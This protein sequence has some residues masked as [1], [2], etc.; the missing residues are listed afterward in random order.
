MPNIFTRILLPVDFSV[1][2]EIAVRRAVQLIGNTESAIHLIHIFSPFQLVTKRPGEFHLFFSVH[3]SSLYKENLK[4]LE[5]W[6]KTLE[7][8]LEKTKVTSEIIISDNVE[9]SIIRKSANFHPFLIILGRH[10]FKSPTSF[11]FTISS[12]RIAHLTRCAVLTLM[13]GI[14]PVKTQT[15]VIPVSDFV[16]ARKISILGSLNSNMK[17][18]V[19]LVSLKDVTSGPD[20][21]TAN[22]MIQTF[23]LLKTSFSC[24]VECKIIN[25][26]NLARGA[27]LFAQSVHAD[28]M[29]VHPYS[30]TDLPSFTDTRLVR[31]A[32]PASGLQVLTIAP[33]DSFYYQN[34]EN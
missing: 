21:G 2:T 16:P 15:V 30:E 18:K 13:P 11:R 19:F 26:T 3:K 6:K 32:G 10:S 12:S 34:I 22:A 31:T 9:K 28:M 25:D 20:S 27:W 4:K 7:H 14:L 23:R 33:S 8:T 1:N 29:L 24:I 17:L 5:Q